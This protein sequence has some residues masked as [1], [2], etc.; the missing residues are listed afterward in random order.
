[1]S[2]KKAN[3]N[4]KNGDVFLNYFEHKMYVV[5]TQKLCQP[6]HMIFGLTMVILVESYNS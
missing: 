3:Y 2:S 5:G 6:K 1:M 4:S